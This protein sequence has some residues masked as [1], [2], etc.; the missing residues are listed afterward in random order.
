[1]DTSAL[2]AEFALRMRVSM[3]EMGSVIF[4]DP[5][6]PSFVMN[7]RVRFIRTRSAD[8]WT[9]ELWRCLTS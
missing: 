7:L 6:S 2:F 1:M 8:A 4:I 9:R 3:S 5:S